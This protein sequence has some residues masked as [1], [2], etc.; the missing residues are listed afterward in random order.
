LLLE[1]TRAKE[2]AVKKETAEQLAAF[3]RQREQADRAL[4]ESTSG[5]KA[6]ASGK[7]G[8]PVEEE[9]WAILGRKRKRGHKESLFSRN[10]RK[11]SAAEKT[12]LSERKMSSDTKDSS[13]SKPEEKPIKSPPFVTSP[14]LQS[15][16]KIGLSSSEKWPTPAKRHGNQ[17]SLTD[18][19]LPGEGKITSKAAPLSLGLDAYSSCEE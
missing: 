10:L 8:S 19:E 11:P 17:A 1:S 18:A 15:S 12:A 14:S 4:L 2:A 3:H 16:P 7:P 9:Q 13:A 6:K 5:E